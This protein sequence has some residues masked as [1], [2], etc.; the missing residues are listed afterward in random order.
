MTGRIR[1]VAVPM[2]EAP[3]WVR[4]KWVGLELP[5]ALGNARNVH[6]FGILTGPRGFLA[7]LWRVLTGHST[8]RRGYAVEVAAA[9]A[10]LE[11]VHP[12]AAA[13]WRTNASH[14]FIRKRYFLFREEECRP[15][16]DAVRR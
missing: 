6:T 2:G 13:W 7:A 10:A 4:E 8:R 15:I 11:R 14:L 9:M 1:I 3:Q 16:D 5:L 12:D